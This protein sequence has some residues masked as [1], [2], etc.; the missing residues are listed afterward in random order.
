MGEERV[1][2]R[3]PAW[4]IVARVL[5]MPGILAG[6]SGCLVW[7]HP[8]LISG[9]SSPHTLGAIDSVA[10]AAAGACTVAVFVVP[11]SSA[12]SVFVALIGS[13]RARPGVPS[14]VRVWIPVGLGLGGWYMAAYTIG[15][16]WSG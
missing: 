10:V 4:A 13:L 1:R 7:M 8:F 11:F 6:L 14:L 5:S 9:T 15:R 12:S 3:L 2:T 16:A